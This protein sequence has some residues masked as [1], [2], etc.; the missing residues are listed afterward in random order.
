METFLLTSLSLFFFCL[1]RKIQSPGLRFL[2]PQRRPPLG[3]SA[4]LF[5]PEASPLGK[6]GAC[7]GHGP[8]TPAGPR[9]AAG[10]STG[11]RRRRPPGLETAWL[12][13]R[14]RGARAGGEVRRVAPRAAR[15][16]RARPATPARTSHTRT[17][18][19][20]PLQRRRGVMRDMWAAAGRAR[21][22]TARAPRGPLPRRGGCGRV[23]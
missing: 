13:P 10:G 16:F 6:A 22:P 7:R 9:A 5:R 23:C 12:G 8:R 19:A 4:A 3:G 2:P 21:R 20:E 15:R 1:S 18:A 11:A 17:A 14:R